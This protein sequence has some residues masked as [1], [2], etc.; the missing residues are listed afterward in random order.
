MDKPSERRLRN[1]ASWA[2]PGDSPD[3][4]LCCPGH[5]LA[6]SWDGTKGQKNTG[7]SHKAPSSATVCFSRA[8]P[9][10]SQESVPN[11]V[12]LK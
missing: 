8:P 1:R 11:L 10:H 9:R 2:E 4:G 6:I 7:L 5:A 3:E 12:P